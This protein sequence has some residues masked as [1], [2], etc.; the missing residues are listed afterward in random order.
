MHKHSTYCKYYKPL[1]MVITLTEKKNPSV[2]K[3]GHGPVLT[4]V[5]TR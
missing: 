2:C 4:S 3:E 1:L 5:A